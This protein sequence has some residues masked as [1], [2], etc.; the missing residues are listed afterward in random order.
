MLNKKILISLV[1]ILCLVG[2]VYALTCTA[3]LDR[4]ISEQYFP[5]QTATVTGNCDASPE[6]NTACT[7]IWQNGTGVVFQDSGACN[8]GDTGT[9]F[10]DTFVIPE[11]FSGNLTVLLVGENPINSSNAR[12]EGNVSTGNAQACILSDFITPDEILLGQIVSAHVAI[13]DENNRPI[14]NAKA[15]FEFL[16]ENNKVTNRQ[17]GITSYDGEMSAAGQI[18]AKAFQEDADFQVRIH[19][20]CGPTGTGLVCWDNINNEVTNSQC[21]GT[22]PFKISKWLNVSTQISKPSFMIGEE[23]AICTNVSNPTGRD[24]INFRL[25]QDLRGETNDTSLDRVL[26]IPQQIQ[27]RGIDGGKTQEQCEVVTM[28][29]GTIIEKGATGCYASSTLEVFDKEGNIVVTYNTRSE[30]CTIIIDKIHPRVDFNQLTQTTYSMVFNLSEFD[31]DNVT[32]IHLILSNLL[33]IGGTPIDKIAGVSITWA[34]GSAIPFDTRLFTHE[35]FISKDGK[36]VFE[37]AV[38]FE[39]HDVDISSV[40]DS[41]F[42]IILTIEPKE[43]TS[44]IPITFA[45][46]FLGFVYL[47]IHL[48]SEEREEWFKI[49]FLFSGLG[50]AMVAAQLAVEKSSTAAVGMRAILRTSYIAFFLFILSLIILYLRA[51]IESRKGVDTNKWD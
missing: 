29:S 38:E 49:L 6:K 17:E 7:W 33:T 13:K 1:L 44:V 47:S 41:P 35:H 25:R 51:L 39:I 5:Q 16:D 22:F 12:G 46:I 2:S 4:D 31:L 28:P 40:S 45:L 9:N 8:T 20:T 18:S 26:I 27:L 36:F 15:A 19:A 34:N 30:N 10:F 23:L 3:T 37:T 24:R 21:S 32:D 50:I 14:S 43:D 42:T 48:E 11:T